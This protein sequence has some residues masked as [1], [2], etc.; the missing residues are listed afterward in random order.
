[1]GKSRANAEKPV[2]NP[3]VKKIGLMIFLGIPLLIVLYYFFVLI[4]GM[5]GIIEPEGL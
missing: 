1:M 5:L 2:L 3:V 4:L